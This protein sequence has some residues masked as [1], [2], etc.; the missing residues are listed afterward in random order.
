[1][2]ISLNSWQDKGAIVLDPFIIFAKFAVIA[3]LA[4]I[5]AWVPVAIYLMIE[6]GRSSSENALSGFQ[7]GALQVSLLG[8]LAIGFPVALLTYFLAVRQLAR[9]PSALF[10]IAAL[11]AVMIT[12]AAYLVADTAAAFAFGV[13]SLIAAMTFAVLGWFWIIRPQRGAING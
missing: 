9:T 6:A 5:A 7:L 8:S 3:I 2:K 4:G 11:S 13:P 10:L 1:M 12:L